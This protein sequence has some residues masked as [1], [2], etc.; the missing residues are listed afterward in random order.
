M[1]KELHK[2][3]GPALILA[4]PGTGKTQTLAMRI[5]YL[6]EELKISPDQITV[7]TFTSAAASNMH[8]RISDTSRVET[9]VKHDL[10]PNK[11]CTMHSLGQGIIK[12]K[13]SE[14]GIT[15]NIGVVYSDD[16]R[17]I[18]AEDAAQLE[19]YARKDGKEAM[20]CRKIG[21]C[22]QTT[23]K[24]CKICTKY[25]K[26]LRSCSAIDHDDQILLACKTLKDYPDVLERFQ[27]Q[28]RH[29]LVD[30]YQD[31]NAGQFELIQ[32]LTKGQS[33]G[34][35]VV[36]DDDQSIYSWRG[37]S[38]KFIRMFQKHFGK[39]STVE[40]L[41]KSYRCRLPVLEG[42]LAIVTQ[43]DKDRLD[44]G[45][46]EYENK[47]GQKVIVH[48]V[49]SDAKE[50]VA[51]RKVVEK[52]MPPRKVLVLIPNKY[53]STAIVS[54][55]RKASIKFTA[56]TRLPGE[57]MP[58]IATLDEWLTNNANSLA[59]RDCIEAYAENPSSGIPSRRVRRVDKIKL[60]DDSLLS[61]SQLWSALL[62]GKSANLWDA[63]SKKKKE[64]K[65]YSSLFLAFNGL[66]VLHANN[67]SPSEFI[68]QVIKEL[69]PWSTVSSLLE[70]IDSW[71]ETSERTAG[72]KGRNVALVT[73]Q[74]AKGLEAD[75]IC[76]IGAEEGQL[77][78][79]TYSDEQL[80]EQSRLMFVT[81]TRAK[82]ELHLFHARN[83]SASVVHRQVH[84]KGKPPDIA[85][86]RFINS[87]PQEHKESRYHPT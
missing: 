12:E 23:E 44:K 9:Y 7:I 24:K 4:G 64:N 52:I 19:G 29:L 63:L 35:F 84:A 1:A 5:K 60:R 49:P 56:P 45:T 48:S 73:F 40:A 87:I 75:V 27:A 54:E 66:K 65:L 15:E 58:L 28:C 26:I 10:H 86:S 55:L 80:A 85:P 68:S 76:V 82:E 74:S 2:I 53:F 77:P 41:R 20:N 61:I 17:N 14:L 39:D 22:A 69:S 36:G 8:D 32:L 3:K 47:T 30:E 13:T 83:R 18:I 59:L 21:R 79:Q 51:V 31:I 6:A 34:L 43:Y 78:R 25:Q 81:M 72:G 71:V 37:G 33:E 38:P 46:L 62:D 67:D 50:A 70:E 16:M 11:I 57:G 42:A